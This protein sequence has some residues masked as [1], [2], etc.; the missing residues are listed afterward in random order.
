MKTYTVN[1]IE[2]T[3]VVCFPVKQKHVDIKL[4][5]FVKIVINDQILLSG[6]RII[7]GKNGAFVSYPKDDKNELF[8]PLTAEMRHYFTDEI[9]RQWSISSSWSINNGAKK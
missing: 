6:I 7:E 3:D 4:R 8:F 9:L 1:G 5:G 2:I